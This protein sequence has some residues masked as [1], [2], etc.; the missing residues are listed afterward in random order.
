MPIDY[1]KSTPYFLNFGDGYKF[2]EKLRAALADGTAAAEL[3]PMLEASRLLDAEAVRRLDRIV[4]HNSRIE[5][6]IDETVGQ[7]WAKLLWVPPSLPYE[8]LGGPYADVNAASNLKAPG[9]LLVDGNADR[10]RLASE[11]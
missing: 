11:P 4:P 3:A 5:R 9:L 1:W 6:L 2:T 7:G 10:Y 8:P